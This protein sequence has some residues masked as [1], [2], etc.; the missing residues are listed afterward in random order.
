MWVCSQESCSLMHTYDNG[1]VLVFRHP[2]SLLHVDIGQSWLTWCGMFSLIAL[3][4]TKLCRMRHQ[5]VTCIYV[6]PCCV[7]LHDNTVFCAWWMYICKLLVPRRSAMRVI[8]LQA[9]VMQ[10]CSIHSTRYSQLCFFSP[11]C[12]RLIL[13]VKNEPCTHK[14]HFIT[15]PSSMNALNIMP[16]MTPWL[17]WVSPAWLCFLVNWKS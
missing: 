2:A 15:R 11:L 9:E 4:D 5:I 16:T 12:A 6:I 13:D 10:I 14:V 3:F 8:S 7:H 17:K 1:T